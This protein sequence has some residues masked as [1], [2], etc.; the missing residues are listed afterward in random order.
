M[1][2]WGPHL[3]FYCNQSLLSPP[4][5]P[6][7]PTPRFAKAQVEMARKESRK[8]YRAAWEDIVKDDSKGAE[9][10]A[11]DGKDLQ[12]AG[13]DEPQPPLRWKG[14]KCTTNLNSKTWPI[15]GVVFGDSQVR[16]GWLLLCCCAAVLFDDDDDDGDSDG[17]GDG[18]GGGDGDGDRGGGCAVCCC[19]A[20]LGSVCCFTRALYRHCAISNSLRRVRTSLPH[21]LSFLYSISSSLSLSCPP[22][23]TGEYARD[24]RQVGR[25]R[26]QEGTGGMLLRDWSER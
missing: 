5:A 26:R 14:L 20:V 2:E 18:G 15:K 17:G 16:T 11:C 24:V 9:C 23:H 10:V 21:T 3:E 19:V 13:K 8:L 7:P 25:D 12:F 1:N 4:T 22:P 6:L